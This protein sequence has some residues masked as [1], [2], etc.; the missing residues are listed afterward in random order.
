MRYRINDRISGTRM[1]EKDSITLEAF[2]SLSFF[3]F[4]LLYN[5]HFPFANK[6]GSRAPHI[7]GRT[8]QEHDT[9]TRLSGKRALSTRLRLPPETWD[10]F[11]LSPVCNPYYK[12][13]A[14]NTSSSELDVGTFR[15]NQYKPLCLLQAHHPNQTRKYKFTRR[16]SE[17]LTVGAP[18]RYSL[19]PTLSHVK[20]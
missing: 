6:R 13:S 11:P 18:S 9:S 8:Q 3:Y 17:T 19:C 20:I 5:S 12:P 15:P 1:K 2:F 14:G 10:P 16:W 7:G 4:F